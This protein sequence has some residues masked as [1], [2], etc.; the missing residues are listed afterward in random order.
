MVGLDA[1]FSRCV[2]MC[3][4]V[5][6]RLNSVCLCV[7][8]WHL[9]G[10]ASEKNFDQDLFSDAGKPPFRHT[11]GGVVGDGSDGARGMPGSVFHN[12]LP[13]SPPINLDFLLSCVNASGV[14]VKC[15]IK[16]KV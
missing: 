1:G 7:W 3:R 16:I 14:G 5:P 12:L 10:K 11:G 8:E 13:A 9:S 2:F 6:S 4:C 15:G